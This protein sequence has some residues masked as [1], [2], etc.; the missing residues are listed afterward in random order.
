MTHLDDPALWQRDATAL[1]A[2]IGRGA[3]SPETLLEHFLDRIARLEP[4]L[5]AF[6]HL[7]AEGARAAAAEAGRRARE[8]RRLGPLDGIPV[9]VKDNLFVRGMPARWGSL[10]F[11]DFAPEQD[12]ICV[13]RLRA[14][15]AV[16]LGKTTTPE[17]ALSGRTVSRI[18]GI[19]RNPWN[20]ALTPGGS[21]GGAAASVAAGMAP[22]AIGTD[23][24]GSTR[25]PAGYTGLYGLRPSTGRIARRHGFPPMALDFQVIGPMARSLRDLELLYDVLAGPDP[26]DPASLRLPPPALAAEPARHFRIGWFDAIGEEA[27]DPEVAETLREAVGL[28]ASAGGCTVEEIAPPFDLAALRG[29][30]STLTAAG[31]ARVVRRFGDRWQAEATPFILALAQ[32]GLALSAADLVDALDRLPAFRAEVSARAWAELDAIVTPCAPAPAWRAE[33]E[34]PARIGGRPGSALTQGMFGGW[35]N[36]I[37]AAALALPGRPH[38]DGR[39]IGVQIIAPCGGETV[40]FEIARRLDRAAATDRERRWPAMAFLDA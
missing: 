17:F 20:P 32:R 25:L 28:L 4:H 23:A 6:A 3:L 13:E 30:W 35:V 34:H 26:R 14:A 19:T 21:S 18:G 36:A 7:D 22:L 24:G 39:P 5:N 33:E 12:D 1:S 29:I 9:T 27:S 40:V 38:P 15:G 2:L 16:L 10:L 31:A 8:G 11:R 37:G